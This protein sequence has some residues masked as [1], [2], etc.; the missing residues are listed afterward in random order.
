MTLA[1]D[2][3]S[4][5]IEAAPYLGNETVRGAYTHLLREVGV[6]LSG[7]PLQVE[8][9]LTE[10]QLVLIHHGLT[11]LTPAQMSASVASA[12]QLR[13]LL[14]R[15]DKRA[16]RPAETP[17]VPTSASKGWSVSASL[18]DTQPDMGQHDV[19]LCYNRRD[20]AIVRRLYADL[21]AAGLRV[22]MDDQLSVGTPAWMDM[23]EKAILASSCVVAMLTPDAKKS[24]W[25]TRELT[26]ARERR[27]P[28]YLLLARGDERTSIPPLLSDAP[29]VSVRQSREYRA[30]LRHLVEAI[31]SV[32][33]N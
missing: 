11:H 18:D 29:W 13:A 12:E 28:I 21:R 25:M 14:S 19:Y 27:L 30:A 32:R 8:R 1:D 24:Q 22:W 16:A 31:R 17:I 5:L 3:L 10:T 6:S 7:Q 9:A 23:A 26:L 33:V 15:R 20:A 2:V 4:S